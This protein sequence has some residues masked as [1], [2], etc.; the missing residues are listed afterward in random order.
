MFIVTIATSSNLKENSN[1]HC[2]SSSKS[3]GHLLA[4]AYKQK[5]ETGEK[6]SR[7]QD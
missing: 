7:N 6:L 2:T 3:G 5:K 1:S 4:P